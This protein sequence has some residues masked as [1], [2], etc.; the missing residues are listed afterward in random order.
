[1]GGGTAVPWSFDF[2]SQIIRTTDP[3][4]SNVGDDS[5]TSYNNVEG[6]FSKAGDRLEF[7]MPSTDTPAGSWLFFFSIPSSADL[8]TPA[9]RLDATN[10]LECRDCTPFRSGAGTASP[11]LSANVPT[12]PSANVPI[13]ATL[14]L[15]GLGLAG[16]GWSRRKKA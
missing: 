6:G 13:P 8:D 11:F 9:A 12:N 15:F 16:L 5:S 3:Q 4:N 7:Q 2:S 1:M 10:L 14:M